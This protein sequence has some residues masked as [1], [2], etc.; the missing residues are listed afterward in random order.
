M[1]TSQGGVGQ[2]GG[3]G[4]PCENTEATLKHIMKIKMATLLKNIFFIV[5]ELYFV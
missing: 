5:R 2:G 3:G 1:G 4:G